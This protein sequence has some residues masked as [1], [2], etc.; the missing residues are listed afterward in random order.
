[1]QHA[2]QISSC[3]VS[4]C[5]PM[6]VL[7]FD[8]TKSDSDSRY[9]RCERGTS[10]AV[11]AEKYPI[12]L[13]FLT[14][15]ASDIDSSVLG[16]HRI[17]NRDEGRAAAGEAALIDIQYR[18]EICTVDQDAWKFGGYICG[19][20]CDRIFAQIVE[21]ATQGDY[22]PTPDSAGITLE[23]FVGMNDGRPDTRDISRKMVDFQEVV[24]K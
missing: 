5:A 15:H 14:Q 23:S 6:K 22:C 16:S 12:C 19:Q 1:M 8:T 7:V 10:V 21:T 18:S 17:T 4:E 24:D 3:L 9:K 2:Y 20:K 11:L 13:C